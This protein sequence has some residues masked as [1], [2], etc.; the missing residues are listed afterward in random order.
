MCSERMLV[1]I[2]DFLKADPHCTD[3]ADPTVFEG[4]EYARDEL[5]RE[6]FVID[7]CIVP[8]LQ[9]LWDKGIKTTCCCCGH[10]SGSGVIGLLTD[11]SHEPGMR[12]MEAPP[13]QPIE[14]VERR[15]HENRAYARGRH[16]GLVE[17]G[18]EDLV[19]DA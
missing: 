5:G 2:P 8:A 10:G 14:I 9:A 17:A 6:C 4:C 7:K 3:V 11:Y 1:P 12:L 18:R 19:L 15:R 13:F 16:D